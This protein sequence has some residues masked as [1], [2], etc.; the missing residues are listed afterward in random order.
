MMYGDGMM[1][2]M[3]AMMW[4]MGF[5]WLLVVVVLILGAAAL[6]KYVFDGNR[7]RP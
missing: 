2:G 4:G 1:S 7:H 6:A 5:I 3:G